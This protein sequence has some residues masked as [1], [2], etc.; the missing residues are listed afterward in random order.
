MLQLKNINLAIK[1]NGKN[2]I[3][4]LNYVL[5]D[6]VKCAVIGEE[7]DGKSTLLKFIDNAN[8]VSDYCEFSGQVIC[9][10][11]ISY[12]PQFLQVE[13]LNKS[14][15]EFLSD[16]AVYDNIRL[17][18]DMKI[19]TELLNSDRKL[20]TLSGGERIKIRLFKLLC[21]NP[22][23]LLLDEP[24]NDIDYNSLLWLKDFLKNSKL[25]IMFVSHDSLLL[26]CV[27]E[28]I[29]HIE[30]LIKKTKCK[31]TI[32]KGGYEE[33][34]S[35]R[36][37]IFER[38]M[39]IATKQREEYD[40]RYK[41]WQ[42]IYERV[43]HEQNVISRQDPA[44]GRCL[45]KKMKSVISQKERFEKDKAN[46]EEIPDKEKSI[47]TFFSQD[48]SIP[49]GKIVLDFKVDNL[50]IEDKLLARNV[51]LKIVGNTKVAIIGENGVGKTTLLKGIWQSLKDRRDIKCSYMP[52]EY[53]DV[54]DFNL[55]PLDYLS[56][57]GENIA[58]IRQYLGNLNFKSDEMI[59]KIKNL[60]GGQ[61]AKLIYLKMVLD[62]SNV[63]LLDEPTRNFSPT[64]V[65]VVCQALKNFGGAIISISHDLKYVEDVCDRVYILK[66]KTLTELL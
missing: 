7:G 29:I 62:N 26:E 22:D 59:A 56:P 46:F 34:L 14:V 63:L 41:R 61:Q 54:L 35:F 12:L 15:V 16:V 11:V 45:K 3:E 39:Q 28:N 13:L 25:S 51:A 66:D 5:Q 23:I 40:K 49:N 55:T 52:Q 42:Q 17:A 65:P 53:C 1:K 4:N 47:I 30:Q 36:D 60:S 20:S 44:G 9:G 2:I 64:S 31:V 32:F 33:Y 6:G 21:N 58:L 24:S 50:V 27:A 37:L 8:S 10:G 43:K 18:Q 57:Y 38:Q 19:Q 48:I